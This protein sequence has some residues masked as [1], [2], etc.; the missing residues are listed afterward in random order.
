MPVGA[1]K[2]VT[3]SLLNPMWTLTAAGAAAM[4]GLARTPVRWSLLASGPWAPRS[5]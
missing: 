1:G 2:K 4:N 5:S 3:V